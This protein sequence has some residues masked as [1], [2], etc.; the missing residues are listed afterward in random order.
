M[1]ADIAADADRL[2][3]MVEN[4]LLLIRLDAGF[5]PT[6][7]R[8]F[9]AGWSATRS[10]PS[11]GAPRRCDPLERRVRDAARRGRGPRLRHD[12]DREPPE[13][14]REVR[15]AGRGRGRR[16]G[17]RRR[18]LGVVLDRGLGLAGIDTDD[19]FRP[20]F[21]APAAQELAGGAGLG[22]A[23]AQRA[24]ASLGGRM[25]ASARDGGGA[26]FGFLLPLAEASVPAFEVG[27]NTPAALTAPQNRAGRR[28][29]RP[30]PAGSARR[31]PGAGRPGTRRSAPGPGGSRARARAPSR[32]S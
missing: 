23:A 2:R 27:P 15:R 16:L 12:R 32:A 14:R 25:W 11:S 1:V 7:S 13:Q 26:E 24:V 20:F 4:M 18:G 5:G 8:S 21:R 28:T 19:L 17:P 30:R 10:R 22:L 9:S 29:F 6:W 31:S 3:V